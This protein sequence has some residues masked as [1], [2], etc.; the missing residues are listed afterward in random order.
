MVSPSSIHILLT[1]GVPS[2]LLH[3]GTT[4]VTNLEGWVG[5]PLDPIGTLISTLMESWRNS[6]EG[7]AALRDFSGT[8]RGTHGNRLTYLKVTI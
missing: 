1:V 6:E 3:K 8:F 2:E 4:S 5:H 7:A